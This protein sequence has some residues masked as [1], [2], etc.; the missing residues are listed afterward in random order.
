MGSTHVKVTIVIQTENDAENLTSTERWDM[1]ATA[2]LATR[3][4]IRQYVPPS[5]QAKFRKAV[6]RVLLEPPYPGEWVKYRTYQTEIEVER[7]K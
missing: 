1:I 5:H 7:P 3:T 2:A 4:A 6:A